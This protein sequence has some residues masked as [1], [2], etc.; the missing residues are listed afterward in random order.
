MSYMIFLIGI[1]AVLFYLIKGT[2]IYLPSQ[3]L[4]TIIFLHVAPTFTNYSFVLFGRYLFLV[5]LLV[6]LGEKES[7][8]NHLSNRKERIN[9]HQMKN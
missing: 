7:E 8:S 3:R 6:T 9:I 4:D 5:R 2:G 1:E